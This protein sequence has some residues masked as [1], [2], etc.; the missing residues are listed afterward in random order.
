MIL[1]LVFLAISFAIIAWPKNFLS[2]FFNLPRKTL[3]ILFLVKL[4]AGLSLSWV[5]DHHYADRSIADTYKYFDD[6]GYFYEVYQSS[7]TDFAKILF[8]SENISNEARKLVSQTHNWYPVS[9]RTFYNDNRTIIRMNAVFSIFTGHFYWSNLLCF[10]WIAFIG[11]LLLFKVGLNYL[12]NRKLE[13]LLAC[14]LF[15]SVVFWTSGILKEAPLLFILGMLVYHLKKV[16]DRPDWWRILV[17]TVLAL[18]LI[19]IKFYA[20][21]FMIPSAIILIQFSYFRFQKWKI[22]VSNLLA[23]LVIAQIWHWIHPR[24]SAFTILKW[25]KNDFV[26]LARIMDANSY[27]KTYAL[28]DNL[29]SFILNIP[30]GIINTFFRP[31]PWEVKN[32]MM[33][34]ATIENIFLLIILLIFIKQKLKWSSIAIVSLLYALAFATIIGMITPIAGSLV[35]YKVP[36]LF[37]VFFAIFKDSKSFSEKSIWQRIKIKVEYNFLEKRA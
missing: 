2:T 13:W 16:F 12:N 6:A 1:F 25:K 29:W 32:L 19:Y 18:S 24:W 33:S 3:V 30:Q 36:L 23:W 34:F 7:K 26:G 11:Q 9:R 31:F 8:G 22:L 21:L 37:F 10:L 28:E 15:P 20:V 35:R 4:F 17:V 27:L 14:F 5:Y